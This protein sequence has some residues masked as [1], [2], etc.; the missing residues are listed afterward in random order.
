[1]EY[2]CQSQAMQRVKKSQ[3]G[4]LQRPIQIGLLRT[5]V[6]VARR[7]NFSLAA[8]DL[9]LTQS[10]VSR[11]IRA[12]ESDV[13]LVLFS[14]NTRSVELTQAGSELLAIVSSSVDRLD[15]KI[16]SLRSKERRKGLSI[17]TWASFASMWL[18]PKLESFKAEWPD[19]DIKIHTADSFS[20]IHENSF[21]FAIRWTTIGSAPANA[22]RLFGERLTPV[23]SPSLIGNRS[24]F[25][26]LRKVLDYTLIDSGAPS[27]TAKTGWVSWRNWLDLNGLHG[28]EPKSWLQLSLSDQGILAAQNSQGIALARLPLVLDALTKG[29]LIEVL[30]DNQTL[31]SQAYWLIPSNGIEITPEQL[32]FCEWLSEQALL[33]RLAI[34]EDQ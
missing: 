13:G 19:I 31:L 29:D 25:K 21:E 22:V 11:H 33:T 17:N 27:N 3:L 6:A 1:M 10:A 12:F 7:L 15:Q 24:A 2:I 9:F 34:G 30:P 23:A 16:L 26:S 32:R 20:A 28:H 8:E 14:R 4:V 5:F 18:I